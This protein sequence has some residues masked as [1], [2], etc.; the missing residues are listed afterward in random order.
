MLNSFILN[1]FIYSCEVF[2]F[3]IDSN[4]KN[5]LFYHDLN[6]CP[7]LISKGVFVD[8]LE[9]FYVI[10]PGVLRE[11]LKMH[12]VFEIKF[13][14]RNSIDRIERINKASWS[15]IL[16]KCVDLG[17]LDSDKEGLMSN[18]LAIRGKLIHSVDF[19]ETSYYRKINKVIK[20]LDKLDLEWLYEFIM[21]FNYVFNRSDNNTNYNVGSHLNKILVNSYFNIGGFRNKV[22][23]SKSN[24]FINRR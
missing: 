22:N 12:G 6:K 17:I 5:E 9:S 3:V 15:A 11:V 23:L 13:R 14:D 8:C 16:Y 2:K 10:I 18:I 21:S 7:I 1:R 19:S 20:L 24:S 4:S